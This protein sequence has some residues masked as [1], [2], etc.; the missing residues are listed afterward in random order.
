[1]SSTAYSSLTPADIIAISAAVIA[2]LAMAATFWQGYVARTHSRISV[3]PHLDWG[4]QS[5]VG[6]PLYVELIN[7]GLGPAIVESLTISW[8]SA[9]FVVTNLEL[10][11]FITDELKKCTF[12]TEWMTLSPGTPIGAGQRLKL[13][14]LTPPPENSQ[15]CEQALSL[16]KR[17][18]FTIKYKS[19]YGEFFELEAV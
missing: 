16:I 17:F 4:K 7:N 14:S 18:R 12:P 6:R 15:S 11:Q 10:P 5:Y 13:L 9:N 19:F 1:M 3:R 8:D 2:L